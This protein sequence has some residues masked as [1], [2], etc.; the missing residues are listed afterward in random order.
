MPHNINKLSLFYAAAS[1]IGQR[2]CN[3]DSL[4][5]LKQDDRACFVV[6]DGLGGNG[7]GDEASG[8]LT[9]VFAHVFNN[10]GNI[11][12]NK[13]FLTQ[14]FELAQKEVLA[15]QLEKG[16]VNQMRTTAVAIS[17]I[18]GKCAWGH[19][20]D[21]RLYRFKR[22]SFIERTLDHSVPQVLALSKQIKNSEIAAHPDRNRLL[23]AVGDKWDKPKYEL[24]KEISLRK[25]M[26]FL[27][28]TDGIWEYLCDDAL[29]PPKGESAEGWLSAIIYKAEQTGLKTGEMDNYSAI[30]IMTV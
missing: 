4:I 2:N 23:R 5:A 10:A 9:E 6:A 15:K 11:S 17:V 1:L 27:L 13:E 3:E 25:G 12:N 19:I 14:A 22:G 29:L 21:S 28:C 26:A 7:L 24:S 30:T 20:G 18:K 8:L 16:A